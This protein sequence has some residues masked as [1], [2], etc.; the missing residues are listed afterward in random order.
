MAVTADDTREV[1][2]A[3]CA[4]RRAANAAL[5]YCRGSGWDQWD[6]ERGPWARD[7]AGEFG[8]IQQQVKS[9]LE[10]DAV[11]SASTQ[12]SRGRSRERPGGADFSRHPWGRPMSE[13]IAF[14]VTAWLAVSVVA[15]LVTVSAID[16]ART[17]QV[18][19][20]RPSQ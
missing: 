5:V 8:D 1:I 17:Q 4:G 2:A 15:A 6:S 13:R 19:T 12:H 9:N 16:A 18:E 10:A 11:V 3:W 14:F 7:A 20:L